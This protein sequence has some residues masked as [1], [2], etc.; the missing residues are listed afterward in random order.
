M[1]NGATCTSQ[2][3]FVVNDLII[4]KK[5]K[6][7]IK[8]LRALKLKII[9]FKALNEREHLPCHILYFS[10]DSSSNDQKN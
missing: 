8:A 7:K 1:V 3:L 2:L 10:T 4:L 6:I 9:N 5:I